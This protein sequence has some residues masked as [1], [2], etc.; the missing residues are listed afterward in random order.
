MNHDVSI[1]VAE[2]VIS[3]FQTGVSG[4]AN[5]SAGKPSLPNTEANG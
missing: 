4:G 3:S 2:Q 1:N 5:A